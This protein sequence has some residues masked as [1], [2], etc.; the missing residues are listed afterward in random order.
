MYTLVVILVA[1]LFLMIGFLAGIVFCESKLNEAK[2]LALKTAKIS[3]D[4]NKKLTSR[5]REMANRQLKGCKI[6]LDELSGSK[7]LN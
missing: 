7:Y 3:D 4:M 5:E 2:D 6:T 1:I